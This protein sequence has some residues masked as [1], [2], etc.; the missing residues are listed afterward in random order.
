MVYGHRHIVFHRVLEYDVH[1]AGGLDLFSILIPEGD[2]DDSHDIDGC[3]VSLFSGLFLET[4]FCFLSE[5]LH[6][7][8]GPFGKYPFV[9][10][11][12]HQIFAGLCFGI[13]FRHLDKGDPYLL[14]S[15][16]DGDF[17]LKHGKLCPRIE[18]ALFRQAVRAGNR[19]HRYFRA[20][21]RLCPDEDLTIC[22][23]LDD[24][25]EPFS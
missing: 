13:E 11:D 17:L 25:I 9:S 20:L 23:I 6:L 15:F 18:T 3:P 14:L 4:L 5:F 7:S 16:R 8:S 22:S 21:V 1:H 2:V 10:V 12:L 24:K 19:E